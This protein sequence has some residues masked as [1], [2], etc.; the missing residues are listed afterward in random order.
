MKPPAGLLIPSTNK[1]AG[2]AEQ[3]AF[4]FSPSPS[5]LPAFFFVGSCRA[6]MLRGDGD[7]TRNVLCAGAY[8]GLPCCLRCVFSFFFFS[9]FH[10]IF[11]VI[12]QINKREFQH[13]A[14]F[15][16]AHG[17]LLLLFCYY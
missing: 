2:C 13:A 15:K 14:L 4:G 7:E 8:E 3:A 6:G 1:Q 5:A 11:V 16:E 9:S 17:F 10:I 12:K